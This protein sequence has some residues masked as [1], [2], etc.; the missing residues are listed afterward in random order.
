M[1]D[2][3]TPPILEILA[4]RGRRDMLAYVIEVSELNSEVTFELRGPRRP[5]EAVLSR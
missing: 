2:V 1:D 4:D 5:C 3:R